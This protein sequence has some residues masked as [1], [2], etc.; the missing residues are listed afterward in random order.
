MSEEQYKSDDATKLA[1]DVF[2]GKLSVEEDREWAGPDGKKLMTFAMPLQFGAIC[3]ERLPALPD[4]G[5]SC[6]SRKQTRHPSRTQLPPLSTAT[7]NAHA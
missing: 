3:L 5:D 1:S 4:L 6:T 2:A 7:T